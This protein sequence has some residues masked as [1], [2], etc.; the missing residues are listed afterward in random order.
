MAS[1]CFDSTGRN[2][3]ADRNEVLTISLVSQHWLLFGSAYTTRRKTKGAKMKYFALAMML[4]AITQGCTTVALNRSTLVHAESS[5]DLRYHEVVENLA[6]IA[7]TPD[8]LPGYS[9]IFAGTT[10]ISDQVQ[11]SSNT[12]W[13]RTFVKPIGFLTAFATQTLDIPS[14]RQLTKNWT[15]DPTIVPEKL[16]AIRAACQ[17]VL[18]TPIPEAD[19]NL[20]AAYNSDAA[21]A[22]PGYYFDVINMLGSLPHNWLHVSN[23]RP[24]LSHAA[25]YHAERGGLHVWIDAQGM[26]GLSQFT[27][28]V[29][30]IARAD[31]G[32]LYYP[33]IAT[34]PAKWIPEKGNECD[35]NGIKSIT[36]YVDHDGNLTPGP[37]IPSLP[38][39]VRTDNV[40]LYADLKSVINASSKAP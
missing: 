1:L 8:T 35:E 33:R 6:M 38:R 29:Q 10:H 40:G 36:V 19:L 28:V 3:H 16:R 31:F 27:L 17:W 25:C 26:E 11:I 15:L 23:S 14:Q 13:T 5:S 18:N 30:R 39:K 4:A 37:G 12:V 32:S 24:D 22:K 9:S 21:S 20:L 34:R 2:D 7:A